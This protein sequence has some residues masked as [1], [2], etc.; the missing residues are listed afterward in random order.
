MRRCDLK[1]CMGYSSLPLYLVGAPL[2]F[3][4]RIDIIE[5]NMR[6]IYIY[7]HKPNTEQYLMNSANHNLL[8]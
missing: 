2:L 6:K 8:W 3:Y 7:V 1:G 4:P 5:V